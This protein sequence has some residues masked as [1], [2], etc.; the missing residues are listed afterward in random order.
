MDSGISV[1]MKRMTRAVYALAFFLCLSMAP[2]VKAA[3]LEINSS[4]QLTGAEGVLIDGSLYDV[5]FE[6]G[7]CT[8]LFNGCNSAS[9]FTFNYTTAP[10]AAHALLNQVFV[11]EPGHPFNSDPDLTFGCSYQYECYT[12]VLAGP[13]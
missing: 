7:T 1:R 8:A 10:D 2:S 9:D 13:G 12:Y 5:T 6:D 4:G 11:D 3:T